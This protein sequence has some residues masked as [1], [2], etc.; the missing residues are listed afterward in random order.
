VP[1]GQVVSVTPVWPDDD[2]LLW[3]NR[4]GFLVP[5]VLELAN[6]EDS[7]V[8]TE[9]L[10]AR[11]AMFNSDGKVVEQFFATSKDGTQVPY[12]VIHPAG[13]VF[14]GSNV[15]LVEAYGGFEVSMTPYYSGGVGVGWLERGGVKV[16]AN[17]RGGSEYGP[18]WHQAALRENRCK[19]Y[20]D[21]EAVAQ[22]L[23]EQNITSPEKLAIVGG[24][25]GGLLVGNIITRPVGSRLFGAALCMVPLLDMKRYSHLLA[26]A[27][28][29][30]EYGD[31]DTK[32]WEFLRHYSAYHKLR[33]DCFGL[34][35]K[36]ALEDTPLGG[37]AAGS[38]NHERWTCPKVLFTTSTRDDRVHPGHSRK[39]VCSLINEAPPDSAP[40]VFYWE[41]TEGGHGCAADNKQ[42]A[43]MW[44]LNYNFLAHVLGLP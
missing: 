38:C 37:R 30:A 43:Y 5:N 9:A 1:P 24:S 44:T 28:W 4:S 17:I 15:T 23:I 19:A 22:H 25:N 29:M 39:M 6:A 20:E 3:L 21:V 36:E 16:V 14:D 8:M 42:R 12:F 35:G 18:K 11:P 26:G 41:N 32:D 27:S 13:M 2:N 34:P 31:P 10:K 7:C 40:M 33:H